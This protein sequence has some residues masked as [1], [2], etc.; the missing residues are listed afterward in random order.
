[1]RRPEPSASGETR[2]MDTFIIEGGQRLS[3]TI[4]VE[5]NKNAALPLPESTPPPSATSA[6]PQAALAPAA[7]PIAWHA[8]LTRTPAKFLHALRR[9]REISSQLAVEMIQ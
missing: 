3:G 7:S 2:T 6:D 5:G 9:R 8:R 1:M 4:T